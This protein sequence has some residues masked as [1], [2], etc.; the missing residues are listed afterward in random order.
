MKPETERYDRLMRQPPFLR[1]GFRPFF[2]GGAIWAVT[3]VALWTLAFSGRF[4]L[5]T[6]FDPLAWHRHEMLF[7]YLSAVVAGFLL[8]AIPNWTGRLPVSGTSLAAL[9][10]L[11]LT[12]RLAVLGSAFV[13]TSVAAF[14]DVGFLATLAFVAGREIAIARNNNLPIVVALGLLALA[15]AF[16]H[17]ELAG[18]ALLDGAGWRL[19]FA[20][21]LM[22][23][24]LVG[25]RIIPSF[26]RN[27][28]AKQG[29]TKALP[30]QPDR[31]D[32]A[33]VAITGVSLLAWAIA[34][35]NWV[36]AGLLVC[37]GVLQFVRLSR[38]AGWRTWREPMV[39]ILHVSYGWLPLG[40]LLL[41]GSHFVWCIPYSSALHALGAGAMGSMT[42]AVMTRVTLGH[43]GRD[44][45]ADGSTKAIYLLLTIGATL[46][47]AAPMLPFDYV[48]T[49]TAAGLLWGSAFVLYI[50]SHAAKLMGPRPDG[51]A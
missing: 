5:P 9:A 46:R 13:G 36:G 50:V 16:D 26:T 38:W 49:I 32:H 47:F 45:C 20:I 10:T 43:T 23:V 1:A 25:G 3:V 35:E 33:I 37:A 7:G 11:W 34:P 27:W 40:L 15:D 12:A 30:A 44:I 24:S 39:F 14:L 29:T 22:L 51:R 8:T 17:A 2:L 19:G 18:L 41:G 21:V 4:V 48:L 31:F 28:L 6:A 42:L